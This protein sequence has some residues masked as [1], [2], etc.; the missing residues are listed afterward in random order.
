MDDYLR[1]PISSLVIAASL[2]A[3]NGAISVALRLQLERRL[4]WAALR[5][6]VQ[7]LLV[8]LVLQSVFR[9]QSPWLVL[10]WGTG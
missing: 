3:V 1:L 10:L 9:W 7:L 6:V 5:T 2:I 8:G 4:F